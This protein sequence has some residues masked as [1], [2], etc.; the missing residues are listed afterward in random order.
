MVA[1]AYCWFCS[2]QQTTTSWL[3]AIAEVSLTIYH[4]HEGLWCKDSGTPPL[5]YGFR[6]VMGHPGYRARLISLAYGSLVPNL[7]H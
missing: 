7:V 5:S 3:R 2:N 4:R 6:L 1:V